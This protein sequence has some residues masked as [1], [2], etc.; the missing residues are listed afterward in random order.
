MRPLSLDAC[1]YSYHRD[2]HYCRVCVL[3]G[4]TGSND[5]K[6]DCVFVGRS[7]FFYVMW[8]LYVVCVQARDRSCSAELY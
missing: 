4:L 6:N 3:R 7:P 5:M 2:N 1:L 8:K